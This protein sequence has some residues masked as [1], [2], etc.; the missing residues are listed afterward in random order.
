SIDALL[1]VVHEAVT[2]LP[3]GRWLRGHGYDDAALGGH[4]TREQL[5]AL[6]PEQP[7][8][9]VHWSV[10][11]C[12]ANSAALRAVGSDATDEGRE[13]GWIVRGP[14]GSP[15]GLLYERATD[16]LQAASIEA[17]S[18]AFGPELPALFRANAARQL[19]A[20]ITALGD[21]YVHPALAGVYDT[22]A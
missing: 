19:A 8:V 20:G 22:A 10:H 1:E 17:Y 5:D 6:A 16:P 11:R 14:A 7:T 13:G 9:L 12:V 3:P 2:A 15:T 21:A 18:R 4:P